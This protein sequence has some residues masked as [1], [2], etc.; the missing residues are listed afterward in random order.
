MNGQ[1]IMKMELLNFPLLGFDVYVEVNEED[2]KD[3]F[4]HFSS[5]SMPGFKTLAEGEEVTFDVEENER[6]LVAKN[7]MKA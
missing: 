7:V 3:V 4:V 1:N 2:G 5:I 6:G